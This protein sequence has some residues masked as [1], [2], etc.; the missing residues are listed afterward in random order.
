[1]RGVQEI[2]QQERE[3]EEASADP[4]SRGA[5]PLWGVQAALHH[6]GPAGHPP[7]H[8]QGAETLPL[9]GLRALLPPGDLPG[10][11]P[12]ASRQGWPLLWE[13][14]LQDLPQRPRARPRRGEPARLRRVREELCG[15]GHPQGPWGGAWAGEALRVPPVQQVLWAGGHA[16]GSPEG[17]SPGGPFHLHPVWE[18]LEHR[19]VLQCPPEEPR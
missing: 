17:A 18:G 7:E 8:P 3:P 12:E 14:E 4:H 15:E 10:C 9:R 16:A 1:M 6:L 2:L 5:L 11:P 19:E 13:P